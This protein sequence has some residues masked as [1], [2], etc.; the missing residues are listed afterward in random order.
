MQFTYKAK[1]STTSCTV[2]AVVEVYIVV[3]DMSKSFDLVA[4][5]NLYSNLQTFNSI[6]IIQNSSVGGTQDY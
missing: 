2:T 6:L 3:V 5:K 1:S 4:G